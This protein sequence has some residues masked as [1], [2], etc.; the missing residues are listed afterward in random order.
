MW[1]SYP[2]WRARFSQNV[3]Q[4]INVLLFHEIMVALLDLP[5]LGEEKNHIVDMVLFHI[6]LLCRH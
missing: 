6:F 5:V 2:V 1:V 3:K 4:E